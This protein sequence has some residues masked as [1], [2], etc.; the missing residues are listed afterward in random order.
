MADIP[1]VAINFPE[2]EDAATLTQ[3]TNIRQKESTQNIASTRTEEEI[4]NPPQQK[5]TPVQQEEPVVAPP[6]TQGAPKAG[7]GRVTSQTDLVEMMANGQIDATQFRNAKRQIN[8]EG[9]V[10]L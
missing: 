2:T 9:F 7:S 4:K 5:Q 10:N 6:S 1:E 3:Q 8:Q